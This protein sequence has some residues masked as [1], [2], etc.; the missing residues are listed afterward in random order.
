MLNFISTQERR[1]Y[2]AEVR[3]IGMLLRSPRSLSRLATRIQ[4]CN[5][6]DYRHQLI[7]SAMLR[8]NECGDQVSIESVLAELIRQA[9][10]EDAGGLSYLNYLA[11]KSLR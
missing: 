8:L 3:L 5:F 10:D 7:W 4:A 2:R 11:R 1:I 9:L 6:T